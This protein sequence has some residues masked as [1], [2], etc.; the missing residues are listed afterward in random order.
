MLESLTTGA[1][2]QGGATGVL[3]IVTVVLI[4]MALNLYK[5]IDSGDLVPK[6]T[7]DILR[8]QYESRLRDAREDTRSWR[9]AAETSAKQVD[10]LMEYAETTDAFIRSLRSQTREPT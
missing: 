5:K 2:V 8:E 6:A 10:A 4:R 1:I 3:A 7:L 9:T